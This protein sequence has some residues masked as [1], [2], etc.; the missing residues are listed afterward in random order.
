MKKISSRMPVNLEI[1]INLGILYF[2]DKQYERAIEEFRIVLE[3]RPDNTVI[4]Y[5]LALSLGET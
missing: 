3:S 4:R 5:Y 1:H 2:E